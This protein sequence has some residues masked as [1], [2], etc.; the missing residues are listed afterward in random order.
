[1]VLAVYNATVM[2]YLRRWHRE[3][4]RHDRSWSLFLSNG[5]QR[6]SQSRRTACRRTE[7]S[8]KGVLYDAFLWYFRNYTR[9]TSGTVVNREACGF[10]NRAVSHTPR[11][12]DWGQYRERD[13]H[14]RFWP[15]FLSQTSVNISTWYYTFHLVPAL[16]PDWFL[17]NVNMPL[18]WPL[19]LF[20]LCCPLHVLQNRK[21]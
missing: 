12:Q 5:L 18:H 16:V 13:R 2:A 7:R 11:E 10:V 20:A 1:M 3:W 17:I 6:Y 15:L 8:L 19:W 14:N 9:P 4:D 21:Q